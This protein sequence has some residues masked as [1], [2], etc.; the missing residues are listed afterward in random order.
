MKYKALLLASALSACT[1]IDTHTPPP[2]D[3][4]P[5]V[6]HEHAVKFGEFWDKCYPA[7]SWAWRLVG[8]LPSACATV[9]FAQNRCD[10]WYPQDSIT[11]DVREHE[12]EH[13]RGYDHPGSES[14][15][16]SWAA[17]KAQHQT[18]ELQ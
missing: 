15:H 18:K 13:C 1:T 2:V 12:R 10:I 16:A 7:V 6:I 5:V 8:A 4:P 3:W 17:Y 11:E 14:L 9:N